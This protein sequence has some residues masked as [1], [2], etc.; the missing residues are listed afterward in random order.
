MD[1]VTRVVAVQ[2]DATELPDGIDFAGFQKDYKG[3]Y[4]AILAR[5]D[6][7]RAPG[8]LRLRLCANAPRQFP[9]RR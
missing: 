2:R 7:R 9:S 6:P 4:L 8:T 3:Q 1:V 5:C